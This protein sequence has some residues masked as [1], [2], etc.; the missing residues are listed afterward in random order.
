[1]KTAVV[2]VSSSNNCAAVVEDAIAGV[3][4]GRAGAFGLV[5]G[6]DRAGHSLELRKAGADVVV[7]DLAQMGVAVEPPST[8]SLKFD[9]F[10]AV[11]EGTREALCSWAMATSRRAA[12]RR[13]RSPMACIIPARIWPGGTTGCAQTR[14]DAPWS[15]KTS[16]TCRIG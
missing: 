6:V 1:M 4:A 9:G 12:P 7:G 5:V 16:S 3:Q 13:V 14:P 8:W 11:H 10:D 2:Y 15:R